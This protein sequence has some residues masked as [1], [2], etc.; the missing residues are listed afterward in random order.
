MFKDYP[1]GSDLTILQTMYKRPRKNEEGKLEPDVLT[2][3]ARD[4]ITG[5]KIKEEIKNP[6][7]DYFM[8]NDDVPIEHHLDYI[9]IDDVHKITVPYKDLL[10]SIA[11]NTN[12]LDFFYENI[13]LGNRRENEK[14][15]L[16]WRVFMSDMNIEDQYRFKFNNTYTNETYSLS[17]AFLDIEVRTRHMKGDFPE[18]GECPI[19]AITIILEKENKVMTFL[20]RD[21]EN[22]EKIKA[23]E[24]EYNSGKLTKQLKEFVKDN[25]GGWK[26]EH[27]LGLNNFE[28]YM[29]F[30]DEEEEINLIYDV[31]VVINNYKPDFVLAWN[32]SFDIPQIIQRIVNLGYNPE[33]IICPE[34]FKY[35]R[36][37]YYIDE[38][39]KNEF[40]E[41]CDYADISSYSV[42]I[43]Q[44][45]Q[46]ASRRKGQSAF[47]SFKLD[48]I[49]GEIAKVHKYDY[50]DIC[51]NLSFLS[52]EDYKTYV[53]YNIMDTIVQKCI[54]TK[55]GDVDY[56]F[57]KAL[58]NNT[59]YSKIHRQT[60]YLSN[61]AAKE[62]LYLGY[63]IGNNPN[64]FNSKPNEKFP[65]AYVA[66]PTNITNYSKLR[67][68]G[69]PINVYDNCV[70]FD[71]TRLYPSV[72]QENNMASHTQIGKI[73]I[74]NPVFAGDNRFNRDRYNRGGAFIE[75][76]QSGCYLE[77]CSRWFALASFEELLD[78]I[79]EYDRTVSTIGFTERYDGVLKP[80][81]TFN[82]FNPIIILDER[83]KNVPFN[84]I[85]I[86]REWKD[87]YK[88]W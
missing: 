40:A 41:R 75:D 22:V 3:V 5:K 4:N 61:R 72:I 46:F 19:D 2:L 63:I 88:G 60:V 25:V 86:V 34:D 59:K 64:K 17:K 62:Y 35:K 57:N 74:E 15:H 16:N 66:D 10:K 67:I 77:F 54:E 73:I 81:R 85:Y 36:V 29:F 28:Y 13:K 58:E 38:R 6:T 33:D 50:H 68:D 32:M 70:D 37:Y 55:T 30:Y 49:G 84:P 7:Y 12:N 31:F 79:D 23:F 8:A 83:D 14:L 47:Q 65:G 1:D 11:E 43:D 52:M 71:F 18:P 76:Y 87:V 53:F 39:N 80:I 26:E 82:K 9:S 45:I 24:D 27:R 56:I 42:Y 20:L 51:N 69:S 78:D 48:Y 21:K 44:M